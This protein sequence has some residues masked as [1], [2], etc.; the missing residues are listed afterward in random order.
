MT[1]YPSIVCFYNSSCNNQVR[2]HIVANNTSTPQTYVIE[3]VIFKHEQKT[4]HIQILWV[5][6][7]RETRNLVEVALVYIIINLVVS[8]VLV[9]N[10]LLQAII[11]QLVWYISVVSCTLVIC[12]ICTPTPSFLCTSSFIVNIRQITQAHHTT[13]I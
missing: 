8:V 11:L 1:K 7:V 4:F 2:P 5:C 13:I 3:Y 9:I 10:H 12:L 6:R